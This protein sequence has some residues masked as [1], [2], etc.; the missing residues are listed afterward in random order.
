MK[1]RFL[2][3]GKIWIIPAVTALIIL[4]SAPAMAQNL[5]LTDV[6]V[7]PAGYL[8]GSLFGFNPGFPSY[9]NV[10]GLGK[11]VW[12]EM[13][14]PGALIEVYTDGYIRL[15]EAEGYA[16]IDYQNGLITKIGSIPFAYES[17]RVR[18]IGGVPLEYK[19]GQLISIGGIPI[20]YNENGPLLQMGGI[21]FAYQDGRIVQIS[22]VPVV[23][24]LDGRVR[25]VGE[26]Q[27]AYD[28]GVLKEIVG[29]IP[30]VNIAVTSVVEFRKLHK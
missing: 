5:T 28:Y 17:G 25:R 1:K 2:G 12:I 8:I 21:P 29:K 30:G 24:D 20:A 22:N 23:Y 6:F 3:S 14:L 13:E 26:V 7:S 11:L 15:I 16:N 4:V 10:N 27:F 19:T 9:A 18:S